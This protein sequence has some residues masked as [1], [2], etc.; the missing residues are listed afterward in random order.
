MQDADQA[1]RSRRR[2]PGDR[3]GDRARD[4]LVIGPEQPGQETMDPLGELA[5]CGVSEE[6]RRDRGR[7]VVD[8]CERPR[9]EAGSRR[10]ERVERGFEAD[11]EV[12]ARGRQARPEPD[13]AVR[14]RR[15]GRSGRPRPGR[16]IS[17][18]RDARARSVTSKGC[19][20]FGAV[21]LAS[22]PASPPGAAT[23]SAI[24]RASGARRCQRAAAIR[25]PSGGGPIREDQAVAAEKSTQT[26]ASG[27]RA[28]PGRASTVIPATIPSERKSG[29]RSATIPFGSPPM[30]PEAIVRRPSGVAMLSADRKQLWT[31]AGGS[32]PA[33]GNGG[34]PSVVR[35]ATWTRSGAAIIADQS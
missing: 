10:S 22:N 24:R 18:V 11:E 27:N 12:V 2:A 35:V 29:P 25:A 17:A 5:S 26:P 14:P 34:R 33:A 19:A 9:D 23:S 4:G 3:A 7:P 20:R 16:P 21:P 31:V 30:D 13:Q 32:V 8:V 6:S 15:R 28:P 1:V